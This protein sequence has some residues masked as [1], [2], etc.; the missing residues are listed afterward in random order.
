MTWGGPLGGRKLV[1]GMWW[2]IFEAVGEEIGPLALYSSS[3]AQRRIL[4]AVGLPVSPD[5]AALYPLFTSTRDLLKSFPSSP[6]FFFMTMPKAGHGLDSHTWEGRLFAW[7][8]ICSGQSRALCAPQLRSFGCVE[9]QT[10][11]WQLGQWLGMTVR[12]SRPSAHPI[13]C[14]ALATGLGIESSPCFT[15]HEG[16]ADP[17][18]AM[19]A[20]AVWAERGALGTSRLLA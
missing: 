19:S 18:L 16:S 5:F 17:D 11:R 3:C 10:Q 9:V 13:G 12:C 8:I 14:P 7:K 15:C 6:F 4:S 20:M 2:C 1:F